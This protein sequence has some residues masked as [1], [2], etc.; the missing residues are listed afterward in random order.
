MST[1]TPQEVRD[2]KKVLESR[3]LE[4]AKDEMDALYMPDKERKELA[5][6]VVE[7]A[8]KKSKPNNIQSLSQIFRQQVDI[9]RQALREIAKE[10]DNLMEDSPP[11]P[12][13]PKKRSP[14]PAGTR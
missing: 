4:K 6:D 1:N 14:A 8:E 10:V 2:F 9:E 11:P 12:S 13:A 3:F 5:H 7:A